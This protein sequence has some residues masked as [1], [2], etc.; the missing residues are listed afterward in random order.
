MADSMQR[1]ILIVDDSPA[2]HEDFQKILGGPGDVASELK[3]TGTALFGDSSSEK[4]PAT[5]FE[6]ES[7]HQGQEGLEMVRRAARMGCPYSM[8]FVDVRMPPGWDGIETIS[9]IWEE[10]PELSVVICTAYSDYSWAQIHERLGRSDRLFVLKKPF[11]LIEVEQLAEVICQRN[12]AEE[13]LRRHRAHLEEMVE[14]RTI[15]L[16]RAN[17]ELEQTNEQLER[18]S[19]QRWQIGETLRHRNEELQAVYD[20]L[21]EGLMIAN[22]KTTSLVQANNTICRMLGYSEA[23]LLNMSVRDIHPPKDMPLILA[24]F[25]AM[26][27]GQLASAEEIPFL[28]KDGSIFYADVTCT[29]QVTYHRQS[30]ILVLFH[31]ATE[32]RRVQQELKDYSAALETANRSLGDLHTTAETATRAKSEFLANMSHE[33]RTPMTAILGFSELLLD[34]L[35]QPEDRE[36]VHTIKRNGEYLLGMINDILD[37]SKIEAG[38]LRVENLEYSPWEVISDVVGLMRVRAEEKDL[39]LKLENNGPIPARIHSDPTRLRQ[40][41]INLIGNAVKFTETGEIRIAVEL[42]NNAREDPRLIVRV[43]DSGI[44]MSA[45]QVERLFLPFTQADMSTTRVFGGTG[46]GLTIS[47]RLAE[48][49]GGEIQVE[50]SVGQGST[51]TVS[52]ATGPLEGISLVDTPANAVDLGESTE[53]DTPRDKS[54]RNGRML[55]VEDGPDNQRLI[56]LLLRTAGAD[57]ALADNG[58]SGI[59]YYEAAEKEGCPF[60]LVLMDMQMPVLD[61]YDATRELRSRGATLPI[62]AL[63]AHAMK[64]DRRK[65]LDVG[66]NEYLA[67]PI[68]RERLLE[69]TARL[70]GQATLETQPG[71]RSP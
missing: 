43:N 44:G 47:R 65:C 18:E 9:H 61:G 45:E 50:S 38:M 20:A 14:D 46:L 69:A 1:R 33:I 60:D 34:T 66:C 41:L 36:K 19:E 25:K 15:G 62:I 53:A 11:D 8:A 59:E 22:S 4:A 27:A 23:E 29:G 31:D 49:L 63:T 24:K 7:A 68:D 10:F 17:E 37:L 2:I 35:D 52:L 64:G 39:T 55:L 57:V 21:P 6:I 3:E 54:A 28:R 51:F 71:G 13:Q 70:L 48:L 58:K 30:C 42:S 26:A 32:R 16:A 67:K 5:P 56:S 12:W 40:I